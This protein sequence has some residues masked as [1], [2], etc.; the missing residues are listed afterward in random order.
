VLSASIATGEQI[1]IIGRKGAEDTA[2]MWAAAN[3]AYRP[4][5]VFALVDPDAQSALAFHMPWIAGMKMMGDK[6]TAYVCRGFACDA[7]SNDPGVFP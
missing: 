2:A 5:A 6:A 1:V 7:P 4:F 3:K